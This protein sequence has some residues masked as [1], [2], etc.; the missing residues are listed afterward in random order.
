M[1]KTDSVEDVLKK[2]GTIKAENGFNFQI[3]Y[4]LAYLPVD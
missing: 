1:A 4:S 2:I 3:N